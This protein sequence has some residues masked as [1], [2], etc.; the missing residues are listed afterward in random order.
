M[1]LLY[2]HRNILATAI[3]PLQHSCNTIVT[4]LQHSCDTQA[5]A[6]AHTHPSVWLRVAEC[7]V[8]LHAGRNVPLTS[9][10]CHRSIIVTPHHCSLPPFVSVYLPPHHCTSIVTPHHCD[11][12]ITVTLFSHRCHTMQGEKG[13]QNISATSATVDLTMSYA[14]ECLQK[15]MYAHLAASYSIENSTSIVRCDVG[16]GKQG[17]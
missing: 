15:C 9:G 8:M 5:A 10:I 4:P 11:C 16:I 12:N 2:Y 17:S 3:K 1:T 7:C 6:H 13:A 14:V